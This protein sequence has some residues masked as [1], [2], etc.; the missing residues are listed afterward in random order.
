MPGGDNRHVSSV[1]M[2]IEPKDLLGRYDDVML[3][4]GLLGSL[5][6]FPPLQNQCRVASPYG[7]CSS[8]G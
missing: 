4:A 7:G 3:V 2:R 8:A 1:E 5:L 6:R